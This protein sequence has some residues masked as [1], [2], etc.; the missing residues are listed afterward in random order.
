[1]TAPLDLDGPPACPECGAPMTVK[2]WPGEGPNGAHVTLNGEDV[3]YRYNTA[4]D[5]YRAESFGWPEAA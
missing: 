4:T 1:M 5:I 2:E 3:V